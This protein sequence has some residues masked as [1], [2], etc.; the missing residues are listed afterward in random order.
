[1]PTRFPAGLCL[2]LLLAAGLA[3]AQEV[4][5]EIVV[6][7]DL[8]SLPGGY[9]ESVFGFDKS[10]LETPR[11]ASTI[12]AALLE[13][14]DLQDIDELIALSPGTFTQS[15]FGAAGGLD[16][17]GT[18]G[19]S[20]FRGMR[21]LDN[22]ANYPTP[23]AA[24]DRIDII[25]GPASPI[26]GPSKIGGYVN[27]NPKSARIEETGALLADTAGA[28]NY[29][30]G[31][32][33]TSV[34]SAEIGGP[35]T[36]GN[37]SLGYYL[38]ALTENSGSYYDDTDQ[39]Q[40][41]LQ[42]SVDLDFSKELS[43]QFGGMR[44]NYL[45]NEISGWN[46]LTQQLIDHGVYVTGSPSSLDRDG[47]GYVS[48][49]EF[50]VDGDG[51]TDLNPFAAG[52]A[53]GQAGR[54]A[55]NSVCR[56]G[57]VPVFG[58]FPALMALQDPGTAIIEGNMNITEPEDTL[59]TQV[60]TLYFDLLGGG[61]G[62][63]E[64]KNQLFFEHYD[65]LNENSYGFSQFHDS[66][67][68]ENK[69]VFSRDWQFDGLSAAIQISPS[70]RHT[71]FEHASD[72]TNEYFD[73]YDITRS[74]GQ[75]E[76]RL[77][78]TRIH[79]D[80][81]EYHIGDYTDFG[82]AALADFTFDN[83]VS[84]LLGIRGDRISLTSRQPL[85]K[86]LLPSSANFCPP[87]GECVALAAEDEV[88]GLSW[89]LSLSRQLANGMLPYVTVSRQTTVIAGQ[90][91]EITVVNVRDDAAVDQS[92][93]L[94]AGVKGRMLDGRLYFAVAAY[95]QE[96]TDY[97]AQSIVTNQASRTK[98]VEF[99]AR[100][101]V[102][103]NLLLALGH[104]GMKVINLNTQQAGSRFSYVGA[105]DLPEIEPWELYGGALGANVVS[106]DARRAG[107]PEQ[108]HSLLGTWD[109]D[110]GWT[111]NGSIVDVAET[112]SGFS[113]SVLLPDYTLVNI[114][115]GYAA[116]SWQL[117]VNLKNLTNERYFRA[118]FPNLYGGVIVLP[119]LPRHFTASVRFS[120]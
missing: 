116:R 10:L 17:R 95:S 105:G 27:I 42:V 39:N 112:H 49:Q 40:D 90:G 34:L 81:T 85:E 45:S 22:P 8:D 72:Y 3:S 16:I 108:I 80:Y 23:I 119:E 36:A 104:T 56:I 48:H 102:N 71:E 5:E 6:T 47:D 62:A 115:A 92:R 107:M 76:P 70:V 103:D 65:S 73:R 37:R 2:L 114:G 14:F 13:R 20:Y 69:V 51:F 38:Y 12:S 67:V 82:L 109:F 29:T 110:N 31:S 89:T 18:P 44:H 98:G 87:P 7:G 100:W 60:T 96:R 101:V 120:F 61:S 32:W 57:D 24:S 83:G 93:L 75:V 59:D 26:Y 46:R 54:L 21:R 78:A 58:C 55:G 41:L 35:A 68:V 84:A 33:D 91:A 97:S 117:N 25:R 52:L 111:L 28:A 86:L 9:V 4:V 79:D 66:S 50:D 11:S 15:F 77:L 63:W 94:E 43:A 30:T 64:W 74:A 1:M 19:E 113:R 53:P 88:D 118:N 106:A 99:E